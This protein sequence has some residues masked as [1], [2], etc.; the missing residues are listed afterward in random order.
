MRRNRVRKVVLSSSADFF[1]GMATAWAFA[2]YDAVFR[3]AWID[4]LLA[5]SCQL[6]RQPAGGR[7][8]RLLFPSPAALA[9][10]W[11]LQWYRSAELPPA[12]SLAATAGPDQSQPGSKTLAVGSKA[13]QTLAFDLWNGQCPV[14]RAIA[15]V[16]TLRQKHVGSDDPSCRQGHGS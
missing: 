12:A 5:H 4:L 10:G 14:A 9:W 1:N 15:L 8:A 11:G 7:T 2:S 13:A 3:K 6:L 16:Q